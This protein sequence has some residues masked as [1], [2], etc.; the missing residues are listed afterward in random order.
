MA[1]G[2]PSVVDR[3][4]ERAID[5]P[6]R[7]VLLTRYA[8]TDQEADLRAPPNCA[9]FGRIRHFERQATN[10]WVPNP[11]PIDPACKAL[12]RDRADSIIAQVFQVSACDWR[13]WYCYV[14]YELLETSS[15]HA[16]WL[17]PKEM[18]D[19]YLQEVDRPSVI[20]LTGGNPEIVTEWIPWMMH[21]LEVRGMDRTVYLWSDDNLSTDAFWRFL[22]PDEQ[23][24][25]SA[26]RNY[27][28]VCCFKGFSEDSF[29]FNTGQRPDLFALQFSRFQRLLTSG[30]DL[31]AYVTLTCR[32]IANLSDDMRI[33]VDRLQD[34]D[35]RLP[36]RTVPLRIR[37]WKP[38]TSRL[39]E[40]RKRALYNYQ[41]RALDSWIRT[42]EQRFS[43]EERSVPITEVR[44]ANGS[45][46]RTR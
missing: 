6:N 24:Y 39:D 43:A 28:R 17:S 31:Y 3:I 42:I 8:G 23:H 35:A 16:A 25:V 27:G 4:R 13:C 21:E 10:D 15:H 32:S 37:D 41:Y 11:L 33:F 36:L 30:M 26:Y 40:P 12:G 9:G 20:D 38:T 45:K 14:P 19:L 34:I 44:W 22:A 1:Q 7:R 2:L 18:V 29:E 46:S 5:R